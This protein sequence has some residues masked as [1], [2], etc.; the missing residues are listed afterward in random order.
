MS[1]E[2]L[3]FLADALLTLC[4]RDERRPF[5]T[6][7]WIRLKQ[8]AAS[9]REPHFAHLLQT[10]AGEPLLRIECD[11]VVRSAH[12]T[13]RQFDVLNKRLDGWTFEEIGNEGG[14]SKQGAQNIFVQALKKLLRAFRTYPYK[15]LSDVYRS[16][17]RRGVRRAGSGRLHRIVQH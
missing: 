15:G 3:S 6:E 10:H 2:T 8:Q 16:E 12:L 9:R 17:T 7:R 4:E 14:H 11:E 13:A 1:S 5:Y